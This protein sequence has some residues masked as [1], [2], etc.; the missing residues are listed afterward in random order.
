[1][2]G[3]GSAAGK[4]TLVGKFHPLGKCAMKPTYTH[5][6]RLDVQRFLWHV[7]ELHYTNPESWGLIFLRYS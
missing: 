4:E 7:Y 2:R 6:L 3:E 1:M 5:P